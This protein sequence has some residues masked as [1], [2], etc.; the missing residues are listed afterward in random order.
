MELVNAMY[1]FIEAHDTIE[2]SLSGE[3]VRNLLILLAT[4]VPHMTEAL[5][6]SA[7]QK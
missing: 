5:W 7:G 3:L 6:Q 4:F 1:R 2:A